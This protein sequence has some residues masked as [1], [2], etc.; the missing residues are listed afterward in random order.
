MKLLDIAPF[1]R[2]SLPESSVTDSPWLIV[3]VGIAL[4]LCLTAAVWYR[5]HHA[6][7]KG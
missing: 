1:P 6:T 7:S 4:L 3:A 5:L 2:T